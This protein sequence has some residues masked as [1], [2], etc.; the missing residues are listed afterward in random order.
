MPWKVYGK[1]VHKLTDSGSKGELVK[2][3]STSKQARA[4]M[5][6]LYANV[7]DVVQK[8]IAEIIA[9]DASESIV[10]IEKEDDRYKITT[11]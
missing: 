6:A 8:M 9:D 3:H 10:Q 4:H 2:C 7:D 5:R 11:C 1:C